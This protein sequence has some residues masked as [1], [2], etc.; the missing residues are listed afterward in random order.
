[1]TGTGTDAY[2]VRIEWTINGAS[3][4]AEWLPVDRE[5]ALRA[6]C[7]HLN[8]QYGPDTHRVRKSNEQERD[9]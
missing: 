2:Q 1:M 6:T 5:D 4:H 9:A 3:G 8:D 7:N